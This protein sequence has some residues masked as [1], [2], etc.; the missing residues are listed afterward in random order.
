MLVLVIT[1][2]TQKG[3]T[4]LLIAMKK[5]GWLPA[6]WTAITE[7]LEFNLYRLNS[8]RGNHQLGV[9]LKFEKFGLKLII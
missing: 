6:K 4:T 5:Q 1:I 3:E 7:A 8:R 9:F 2:E